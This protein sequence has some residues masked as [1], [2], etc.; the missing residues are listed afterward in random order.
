PIQ[1]AKWRPDLKASAFAT[2]ATSASQA[3]FIGA[4]TSKDRPLDGLD[5][6]SQVLDSHQDQL[7]A[8]SSRLRKLAVSGESLELWNTP[9]PLGSDQAKLGKS[10]A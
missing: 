9:Y 7:G 3:Q 10:T 1:A 4:M 5:F 2:V 8:G 6:R